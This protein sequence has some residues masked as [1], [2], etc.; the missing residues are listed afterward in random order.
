MEKLTFDPA[1]HKYTYDGKECISVT[2]LLK[3]TKFKNK[4]A[5]VDQETLATASAKG[6]ELHEA[7]EL[8]E[9]MG[10]ESNELQEFRDY[11]FL[12]KMFKF[13]VKAAELQVVLPYKGIIVA[14][15]IDQVQMLNSALGLADIKRTATL[16]KNYLAYQLNLYRLAY[17]HT[18]GESPAFLRGIHLRD[19]VRKYVRI[20]VNEDAAYEILE[21]YIGGKLND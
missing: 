18:Y 7:I 8:Y 3:E 1:T 11:R 14:G 13:E 17:I 9:T 20:P 4:Y 12:K 16:D 19:G 2:Q 6:T 10:L 5:G 21:E 15:T